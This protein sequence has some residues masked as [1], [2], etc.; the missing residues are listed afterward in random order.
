MKLY[1]VTNTKTAKNI[2]KMG[3]KDKVGNYGMP[4]QMKGVWF[5]NGILGCNDGVCEF[6]EDPVYF[7]ISIPLAV[8]K[9]REVIEEAKPY[10]EWCISAK[11]VNKYFINRGYR[12]TEEN[13]LN[14]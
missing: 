10:R 14:N 12:P 11:T 8:I 9:D 1:H 2:V 7:A 3:F 6:D 4:I 13:Y 5:A